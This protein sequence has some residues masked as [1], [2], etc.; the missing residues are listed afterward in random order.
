MPAEAALSGES[1]VPIGLAAEPP[2]PSSEGIVHLPREGD[3]GPKAL[4]PF[5]F[6]SPSL[7][8]AAQLRRLRLRHDE[9]ARSVATRLSIQLRLEFGVRVLELETGFYSQL[10]ERLVNPTHV[11]L[12]RIESLDGAGLVEVPPKLGMAIVER[13]LGGAGKAAALNRDLTEVE[14]ALLDQ[15]IELL[16]KEWCQVV[17]SMP[18]SKPAILGHETNPRFSQIAPNDTSVLILALEI[19]L[20]DCTE[21]VHVGVTYPML[22]AVTRHLQPPLESKTES[23]LPPSVPLKWNPEL[24]SMKV[25]LSVEWDGLEINARKLA[26]LKVGDVLPLAPD[27]INHASVSLARIPKFIGRLGK[28]GRLWAIELTEQI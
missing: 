11:A 20:N 24:D 13:L 6:R 8:T 4:Q 26:H 5:N 9:F 3:A 7:L 22:Q 21:K 14:A 10:I 2:P 27:Q 23:A 25:A 18:D 19:H 16:L 15:F 1:I 12:F 17:A 28:C